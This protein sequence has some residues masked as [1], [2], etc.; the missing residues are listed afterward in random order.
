VV[1]WRV[2]SHLIEGPV[3]DLTNSEDAANNLDETARGMKSGK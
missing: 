3:D 1:V 2:I